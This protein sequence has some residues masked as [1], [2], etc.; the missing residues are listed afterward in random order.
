MTIINSG[1]V[2]GAP[3]QRGEGF[4]PL[5]EN[6][7]GSVPPTQLLCPVEIPSS[8]PY[9]QKTVAASLLLGH[10]VQGIVLASSVTDVQASS[11]CYPFLK[12]PG[13]GWLQ[14]VGPTEGRGHELIVSP[15]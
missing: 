1:E 14:G 8:V 11:Q 13:R 7:S 9:T 10:R 3:F 2:R 12:T 5:E 6:I 4:S 15:V